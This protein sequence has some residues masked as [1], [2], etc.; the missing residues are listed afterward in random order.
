MLSGTLQ[1]G[2]ESYAIGGKLRALRL[3][4]KIGL[5][6][7][8]KHTGLSP[9]LLSKL[10]RGRLFPTL[11]TLLRIALVFSVDL[12]H[13]FE[14]S[15]EKPVVAIVRKGDRLR[16]PE[17][18]RRP[19]AYLFES[20]NFAA[21]DRKLNAYR[22]EFFPGEPGKLRFHEHDGVEFIYVLNGTLAV[23]VGEDEHV[24]QAGDAMYF[25]SNVLHAYRRSGGHTCNAI[26]V[27][28]S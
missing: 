8:G 4:R 28:T 21:T 25:N 15:R 19:G 24:L 3:K 17:P 6:E 2:L 27:T 5:V 26:V 23:D 20:L 18:G 9:A 14:A 22:A 10:E 16:F 12:G 11:P 13:F 7:L 1:K